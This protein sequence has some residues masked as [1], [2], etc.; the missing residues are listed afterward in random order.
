MRGRLVCSCLA[1]C[2]FAVL[3][4]LLYTFRLKSAWIIRAW[5]KLL[6]ALNDSSSWKMHTTMHLQQHDS[7]NAGRH[8]YTLEHINTD[9]SGSKCGRCRNCFNPQRAQGCKSLGVKYEQGELVYQF[10]A[11]PDEKFAGTGLLL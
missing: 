9:L 8:V 7:L 10:D 3:L 1:I 6:R 4:D 2:L 11:D 5:Q